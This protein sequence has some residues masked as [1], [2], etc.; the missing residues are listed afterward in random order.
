MTDMFILSA[1]VA[2]GVVAWIGMI[3]LVVYKEHGD[4]GLTILLIWTVLLVFFF[5]LFI[6]DIYS[7]EK[8][9][10]APP[11]ATSDIPPEPAS[12]STGG[13]PPPPIMAEP[14]TYRE[15]MDAAL[16]RYG[17]RSIVS[18]FGVDRARGVLDWDMAM[19]DRM[20][21]EDEVVTAP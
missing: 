18:H 9:P 2:S 13:E 19:C 6:F 10:D 7:A 11:A 8:P 5:F 17:D 14:A 20:F 12:T 15:C 1:M 16:D 3:L 4:A 21:P